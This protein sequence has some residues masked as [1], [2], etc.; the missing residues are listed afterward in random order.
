MEPP[1][2]TENRGRA[3]GGGIEHATDVDYDARLGV[4]DQVEKRPIGLDHDL[5]RRRSEMGVTTITVA[6]AAHR[7]L[8][9]HLD[10]GRVD[11]RADRGPSNDAREVRHAFTNGS[12]NPSSGESPRGRRCRPSSQRGREIDDARAHGLVD[13]ASRSAPKSRSNSSNCP[14]AGTTTS[15]D[16]SPLPYGSSTAAKPSGVDV[17]CCHVRLVHQGNLDRGA[18]AART[19]APP[20]PTRRRAATTSPPG[21]AR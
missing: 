12:A 9:V 3:S 15:I 1:G 5:G 7:S 13:L 6:A 16:S 8:L 14:V 19:A 4:A 17:A 20:W 2:S 18:V 11:R 10:V 21:R